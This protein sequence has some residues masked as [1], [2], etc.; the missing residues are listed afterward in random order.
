MNG[1]TMTAVVT[2]YGHRC[3][4]LVAGD[5]AQDAVAAARR[6]FSM[7]KIAHRHCV[8]RIGPKVY[9]CKPSLVRVYRH[10]EDSFDVI[11]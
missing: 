11:A 1:H 3:E 9:H 8:V 4:V 10:W 6:A 2:Q 7:R 5:S